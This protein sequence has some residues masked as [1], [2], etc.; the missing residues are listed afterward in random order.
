MTAQ[1]TDSAVSACAFNADAVMARLTEYQTV[2]WPRQPIGPLPRAITKGE[3]QNFALSIV[4]PR[5]N[6][7]PRVDEYLK[8]CWERLPVAESAEE[9]L[10]Y[11]RLITALA[12]V[13]A[14]LRRDEG[15]SILEEHLAQARAE[16][17]RQDEAEALN[18]WS[19]VTPTASPHAG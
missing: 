6:S 1:D 3:A 18:R 10:S 12:T 7:R 8:R 19:V 16:A 13:S 11:E 5:G 4:A 15:H 2:Q 17:K 9:R 14:W